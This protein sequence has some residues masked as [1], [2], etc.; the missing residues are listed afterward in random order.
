IEELVS[1]TSGRKVG[2]PWRVP[3]LPC[4]SFPHLPLDEAIEQPGPAIL[5]GAPTNRPR[6]GGLPF[7]TERYASDLLA[8]LPVPPGGSRFQAGERPQRRAVGVILLLRQQLDEHLSERDSS[9]LLRVVEAPSL[10]DG[11]P[12]EHA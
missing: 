2:N 9:R 8:L 12:K 10:D 11:Q 3:H 6:G 4:S 5:L 1:R 7:C